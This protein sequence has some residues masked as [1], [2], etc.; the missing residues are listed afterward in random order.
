MN[1]DPRDVSA[2]ACVRMR[3]IHNAVRPHAIFKGISDVKSFDAK[4]SALLLLPQID[5]SLL[6]L[7]P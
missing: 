3:G 5:R 1:K 2:R 7:P 6:K 4:M